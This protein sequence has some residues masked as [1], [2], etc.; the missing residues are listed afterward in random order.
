MKDRYIMSDIK[1]MTVEEL[2]ERAKDLWDELGLFRMSMEIDFAK[3]MHLVKSAG[4]R[5]RKGLKLMSDRSLELRKV[6]LA[7]HKRAIEEKKK[8]G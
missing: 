6:L 2:Q 3:S 5:T 7:L 4:V 8:N 1:T